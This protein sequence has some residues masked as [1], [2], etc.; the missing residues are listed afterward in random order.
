[1]TWKNEAVTAAKNAWPQLT[2]W[3][4]GK[5]ILDQF[6]LGWVKKRSPLWLFPFGECIKK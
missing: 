3:P 5:S 6:A 2:K 1:M 4:A